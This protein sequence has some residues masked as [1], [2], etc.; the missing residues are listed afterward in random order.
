M[1]FPNKIKVGYQSR[2][3]TYSGKLAYVIYYDNKN[4]LR[5]EKSFE[6]WRDQKFEPNEFNNEPT[7]GFVLNKKVGGG[8]SGWDSRNTY[9]RVYDPRGFEF[10]IS[11]PNLVMIL[12]N[13][14]CIAGK[15]LEGDFVYGWSGTELVLTP[16]N[17]PDYV[18]HISTSSKTIITD[19]TKLTAK[20]LIVG[21]TYIS[22]NGTSE[23]VYLGKHTIKTGLK[24]NKY[25]NECYFNPG[26]E[27]E[28]EYEEKFMFHNG[29]NIVALKTVSKK[30]S[31]VIDSD[32]ID[33]SHLLLELNSYVAYNYPVNEYLTTMTYDEFVSNIVDHDFYIARITGKN[34]VSPNGSYV[35]NDHHIGWTLEIPN[36]NNNTYYYSVEDALIV[37]EYI[38][39]NLN[40][41]NY[42]EFKFKVIVDTKNRNVNNR[43]EK[44]LTLKELYS[45]YPMIKQV[46]VMKD[47][48]EYSK[49]FTDGHRD[50]RSTSY[51]PMYGFKE[52]IKNFK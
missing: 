28:N 40:L 27:S 36:V 23:N 13:T 5:K 22:T 38:T 21:K 52:K 45:K 32:P 9:I 8:R 43:V 25:S 14:D 10:E 42:D 33:I 2:N 18:D 41:N 1:F 7:S 11:V 19:S 50:T 4:I 35:N 31:G 49:L 3:D 6:S 20:S 51:F 48:T 16:V 34:V 30:F 44:T 15:G 24:S 39:N 12:E 29:T 47:G 26:D 17:S 37:S 46:F